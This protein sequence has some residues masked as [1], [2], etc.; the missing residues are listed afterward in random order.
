M[1]NDTRTID[2][3]INNLTEEQFEEVFSPDANELWL[4][5]DDTPEKLAQ[6][7]DKTSDPNKIYGTDAQG[8]QTTY[9]TP[10][11]PTVGN[12]TITITQGGVT[13]G[14]FT[15]NQSGNTTIALDAGG[16][17][18]GGAVDSVNGKTGVV[19]LT[20]TDVGALPDSTVIPDAQIQSDWNQ[21]DN[22]KVDFIKNKPTI[23]AAQVNSDWNANSGIAQILNKPTLATVATSGSYNDLSNKPT[24]PTVNNPTI[25]ITQ[26]GV[27]KGSFT[28]NQATGKTIA[29][30]AGGGSP[31][32]GGIGGTLSD[33]TD[34]Q[35]ALNAKQA[36]ITGG[37]TTITSS[38]LTINRAVIS[39]G[40]GKVAVST[41]TS[42]ELGYLHGVTSAI[43]TQLNDKV[44]KGHQVVAFQ[45]P[46]AANNYTWYRLYADGWV[47]QGGIYNPAFT[48][49]KTFA[50]PVEMADTNYTLT[51]GTGCP[52][53]NGMHGKDYITAKTTTGFSFTSVSL[54]GR[55]TVS[56]FNWQ[57][58]GMAAS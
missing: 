34:L 47:E 58:S 51:T 37:A 55:F 21:A 14:S 18:G 30:D 6:K 46:T 36:T 1:S 41:T 32:W 22:T 2:L 15:T 45:A 49:T 11:I 23:P 35:N 54:S 16:G 12:G 20:A 57:V 38:N 33:Q 48:G 27:T 8:N 29:L 13:K 7:V 3:V 40:S 9:P 52:D 5:P 53:V 56:L 44:D 19:V 10:T 4:T 42:T 28:L 50:Y 26:G 43:Q 25:T 24:M 39:N 17:G 31:N